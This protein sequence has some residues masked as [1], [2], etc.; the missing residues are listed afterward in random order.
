MPSRSP[1]R[2]SA[3]CIA[4]RCATARPVAVKVQR[5]GIVDQV[6]ADLTVLDEI[7]AF[8]DQHTKVGRRYEFAP[9]IREFR[10]ALMDE[11]DYEV[12]ANHL[13]TLKQNLAE[14]PRIFVPAPIDRLRQQARADDGV[15]AR[16]RRSRR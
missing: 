1:R 12:E 3:R 11:L 16:A 7:A 2:R 6:L 10:K 15:R 14:F 4:P 9:M 13:R 8:V 5:P